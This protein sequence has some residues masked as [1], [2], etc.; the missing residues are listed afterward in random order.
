MIDALMWVLI[1]GLTALMIALAIAD[2][3]GDE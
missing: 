3:G 1:S 2:G